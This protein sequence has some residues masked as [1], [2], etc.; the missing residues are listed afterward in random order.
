MKHDIPESQEDLCGATEESERWTGGTPFRSFTG[1]SSELIASRFMILRSPKSQQRWRSVEK[2]TARV[3]RS[4]GKSG[5][6][7]RKDKFLDVAT[8]EIAVEKIP[9]GQRNGQ[10]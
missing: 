5:F 6:E 2:S 1:W 8:A 10:R 3:Y 7:N 4:F 9:K